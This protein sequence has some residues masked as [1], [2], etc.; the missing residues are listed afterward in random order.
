[1]ASFNFEKIGKQVATIQGGKYDGKI[2][3]IA[4]ADNE[5]QPVKSYVEIPIKDGKF[6]QVPNPD[7]ER[8]ILYVVGPSGSGKSTYTLNYIKQYK[9]KHKGADVWLF[10][11]LAEDETIDKIKPKRIII[12]DRLVT[13]PIPVEEFANQ[14]VIFD[15]CDCIKNKLHRAAVY[16]LL[17]EVLE[18]GRHHKIT[19]I[20]TNHLPT[21]GQDTRRIINE[22]MTVTYFPQS[23]SAGQ[24]KRLLQD[25][26]GMDGAMLKR[27]RK[28]NTRWATIYKNYPMCVLTERLIFSLNPD[29][30]DDSSV[31]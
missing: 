23:G 17:N 10:S 12:D 27:I 15:D 13:D 14:L 11:A 22:S 21:G 26:I 1:M 19:C 24:M 6:Q 5:D 4:T 3:S 2:I 30:S 29:D 25:Y 16:G 18:V 9:K 8:E 28:L 7:A 20:V 31:D